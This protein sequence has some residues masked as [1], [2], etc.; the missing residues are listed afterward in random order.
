M[1]SS[2]WIGAALALPLFGCIIVADYVE[3]PGGDLAEIE[4]VN[5]TT[6]A[7]A[8]Q[9]YQDAARCRH[10]GNVNP[11][12]DPGARHAV[13]VAANRDVAFSMNWGVGRTACMST[14]SFHAEAGKKYVMRF[15]L[16]PGGC[17]VAGSQSGRPVALDKRVFA[18]EFDENGNFCTARE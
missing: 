6:A 5:D 14:R 12:L 9:I 16:V 1:R 17:T 11:M 4:F 2:V 15:E 3:P 10:R 18:P 7:S 8:I 13:R